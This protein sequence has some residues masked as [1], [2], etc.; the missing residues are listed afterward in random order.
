MTM[1]IDP[2]AIRSLINVNMN[3]SR[4]AA[5]IALSKQEKGQLTIFESPALS[6]SRKKNQ[7]NMTFE[8]TPMTAPSNMLLA[9]TASGEETGLKT[10][11]SFQVGSQTVKSYLPPVY[12]S[13]R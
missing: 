2:V 8:P 5:R 13:L 3:K 11:N 7:H 10:N 9:S 4:H 6:P 12:E 1:F